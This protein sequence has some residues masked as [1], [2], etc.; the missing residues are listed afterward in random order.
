[1]VVPVNPVDTGQADREGAAFVWQAT[2]AAAQERLDQTLEELRG[3]GLT[4]EGELGDYRPLVALDPAM[5]EF[6]PDHVVIATQPEDRSSW[7]RHGVVAD[8]RERYDVPVQH[9]VVHAPTL[10]R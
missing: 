8:A 3:R 10:T 4:V 6:G 9:V 1:M 5:S 7:L 2:T